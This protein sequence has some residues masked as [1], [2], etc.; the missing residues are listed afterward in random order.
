[1]NMRFVKMHGLGNDYLFVDAFQEPVVDPA[2]LSRLV[3]DRHRGLGSDG[4]ILVMP[5][6]GTTAQARMRM[7][8][9]D[10]SEGE[11][12]GN[13]IRCLA[14]FMVDRGLSTAQPLRVETGAGE[15]QLD[16]V[17]G[18]DGMVSE[19]SVSMGE[20]RLAGKD[21]P[22]L[23]EGR[24]GAEQVV[25]HPIDLVAFGFD[26]KSVRE[27]GV[28]P[29]LTLVSMGNPH[30]VLRVADPDAVDLASIGP[31]FEHH[32]AFP[33]R[34]NLHLVRV[35]DEVSVTMRTWERGSGLTQACGTGACAVC[36]AGVLGDWHGRSVTATLPGGRLDLEWP[37][38]D[39]PV[40]M[41]G[42]ATMVFECEIDPADLAVEGAGS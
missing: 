25:D 1:M 3:S 32:A 18:G 29:R 4:L 40:R 38:P 20:P 31:R 12:C 35:D 2:A 30:A 14:K 42:P 21:I 16:W 23:I 10:G 11:M 26:P 37:G 28:V 13:G 15:L 8:N 34:I 6:L 33:N 24:S 7:F 39:A 5:P 22:A 19:V 17:R 41:T 36:V 27:G 9:A